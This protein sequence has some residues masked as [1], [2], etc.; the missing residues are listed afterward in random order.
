[1]PRN[2]F[3][4]GACGT[5]ER[6]RDPHRERE[7]ERERDRERQTGRQSR[8]HK[9]LQTQ[10]SKDATTSTNPREHFQNISSKARHKARRSQPGRPPIPRQS[11]DAIEELPPRR[12][13]GLPED[14]SRGGSR[15][16]LDR[17]PGGVP[18]EG[19][20]GGPR[21]WR[22]GGIRARLRQGG[23]LKQRVLE[24]A[25]DVFHLRRPGGGRVTIEFDRTGADT[26]MRVR[27]ESLLLGGACDPKNKSC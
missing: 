25:E 16:G 11:L 8:R 10:A 13:R 26:R 7:R 1:M 5:I 19:G 6:K 15:G 18:A 12:E 4:R 3:S 17:V 21:G 2:P 9:E 27:G 20:G 22:S 23:E 14:P 24:V